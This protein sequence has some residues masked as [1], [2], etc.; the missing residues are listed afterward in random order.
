MGN[1]EEQNDLKQGIFD[2]LSKYA[3]SIEDIEGDFSIEDYSS[4]DVFFNKLIDIYAYS[5]KKALQNELIAFALSKGADIAIVLNNKNFHPDL[6]FFSINKDVLFN[7]PIK[8]ISPDVFL[9]KLIDIYAS[10]DEE[11]ALKKELIDF[12]IS[13]GLDIVKL[14]NREGSYPDIVFFSA[15]KDII[16]ESI[17]SSNPADILLDKILKITL[18]LPY[19]KDLRDELIVFA[20]SKG[21][22]SYKLFNDKKFLPSSQLLANNH[23]P[24]YQKT[25]FFYNHF[26]KGNFDYAR[27]IFDSVSTKELKDAL[28]PGFIKAL[29]TAVGNSLEHNKYHALINLMARAGVELPNNLNL[30]HYSVEDDN[31]TELDK[32]SIHTLFSQLAKSYLDMSQKRLEKKVKEDCPESQE[33]LDNIDSAFKDNAKSFQFFSKAKE[34]CLQNKDLRL[35][36]DNFDVLYQT[37]G[38]AMNLLDNDF[39]L[40]VLTI[41]GILPPPLKESIAV[42]RGLRAKLDDNDINSWFKYGTRAFSSGEYQ[43]FLGYYVNEYWNHKAGKW[44]LGGTY[45]SLEP[46]IAVDFANGLT[47]TSSSNLDAESI[48]VEMKLPDASPRICGASKEEYELV[49]STI[50]GNHIVAIYKMEKDG[51]AI[52]N[53]IKNP[54]L[55]EDI[56]PR[57][58]KGDIVSTDQKAIAVYNSLGCKEL[59]TNAHASMLYK[60]YDTFLKD[61]T[62]DRHVGDQHQLGEWYFA[63]RDVSQSGQCANNFL[64]EM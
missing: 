44:E 54:Y 32:A 59:P 38:N 61:Y 60:D 5:Y 34:L 36:N 1:T 10:S 55:S 3:Y 49:P 27:K 13:K 58:R 19:E 26:Y 29:E 40:Q 31:I 46:C 63:D 45:V 47:A 56:E 35:I 43:K 52:G 48:L 30:L 16:L 4:A 28:V 17:T 12:T 22:N 64:N 2:I 50:E 24:E 33:S 62:V 21:A 42:F 37:L 57:Y 9:N 18:S 20:L 51:I 14:L 6:N 41:N 39:A 7:H 11:K 25:Q 53:V 23:I 15:Y 8:P